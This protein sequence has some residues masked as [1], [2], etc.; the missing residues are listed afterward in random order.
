MLRL[1]DG[2]APRAR[3]RAC[4][5]V[6][7]MLATGEDM[8]AGLVAAAL[9]ELEIPAVSLR[10]GEA[11]IDA[12]GPFGDAAVSGF[13]VDRLRLLTEAG[14][15]PVIAGF[16]A[17]RSDGETVTLGRGGSDMTA[18]FLAGVLGARSCHIVTDV[19]GV[20]DCDPRIHPWA[21][22]LTELTHDGL[23]ELVD[24]GAR[25][26]QPAAAHEARRTGIPL[27]IYS[28][29][30]P[31]GGFHGT[32]IRNLAGQVISTDREALRDA[33]GLALAVASGAA[34]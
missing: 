6:D 21:R 3:S 19:D 16:Q 28:F 24:A 7:R 9:L 33:A 10:G 29:R 8:A 26:V 22:R 20:Y 23:A 2:V 30:A 31:L 34:R 5:E 27:H 18:V 11:G 17:V 13:R 25:V 15:V 14:T 32:S 4:R 1:V 12:D